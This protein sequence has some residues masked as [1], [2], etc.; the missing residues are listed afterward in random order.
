MI[1]EIVNKKEELVKYVRNL[2]LVVGSRE[3]LINCEGSSLLLSN[4]IPGLCD[5]IYYQV[6]KKYPCR[7]EQ[8]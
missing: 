2:Q 8:G 1:Q 5:M 7:G 3:L 4:L 6:D